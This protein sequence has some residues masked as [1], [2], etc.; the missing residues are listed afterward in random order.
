[1]ETREFMGILNVLEHLLYFLFDFILTQV[2]FLVLLYCTH[3]Q[4]GSLDLFG[5]QVN[6]MFSFVSTKFI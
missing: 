5:L 3:P 1:M 4:L 6:Q 2:F